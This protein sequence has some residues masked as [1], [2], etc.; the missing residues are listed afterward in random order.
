MINNQCNQ[1]PYNICGRIPAQITFKSDIVI[2]GMAPGND[3]LKQKKP[4]VGRSGKLL[5]ET[6][7]KAGFD[8]T[9]YITN[10]L[11]CK[12]LNEKNVSR[13]AIQLC[14]P[15]L[16][17]E[18]KKCSP[19]FILA[20]GNTA[21]SSV[22]NTFS[23]KV[24]SIH[25]TPIPYSEDS[26]ITVIPIFHPAKVLRNYGDYHTFLNGFLYAKQLYDGCQKKDPGVTQYVLVNESN[27][28][29][30]TKFLINHEPVMSCDIET[31]SLNPKKA[32]ILCIGFGI[33]KNLVYIYPMDFLP[34]IKSIFEDCRAKIVYHRSQFDT[35]VLQAKG[36]NANADHDT[37]LLHYCLDEN[38]G[39]HDLK[40]LASH[41]L[42]ADNY[43]EGIDK[44]NM[45]KLPK[46]KLYEYLAK[47]ADYTLQLFN[48]F[49]PEVIK[50]PNL[51]KLYHQ[52]LIPGINFLRRVSSNGFMINIPYLKKFKKELKSELKQMEEII[53]TDFAHLWNRDMYLSQTKAKSAPQKLNIRSPQQL[54]WIIYDLLKI[55]PTIYTEVKRSTNVEILENIEHSHKFIPH[56]LKYRKKH[57]LLTTY[58]EGIEDKI[59]KDERLRSTYNLQVTVTGRLSSESPNLQNIPRDSKVKNL[60]KAPKGYLLLEADYS[61]LEVRVLAYVSQDPFLIDLFEQD[62]DI[63]SEMAAK[64]FGPN[65]TDKQRTEVKSVNF[66]IVY[67]GTAFSISQEFGMSLREA[68]MIIDEW[69]RT[70]FKAKEYLDGCV[71]HLKSKQPFITPTGRCRRYGLVTMDTNQCNEAKNFAIQ[72]IASDLTLLSAIE[73]ESLIEPYNAKIINLVHDSIVIQVIN[74]KNKVE[75]VMELVYNIMHEIPIKWLDTDIN[76]KAEIKAGFSWGDMKKIE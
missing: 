60:F 2:V 58:I 19:K 5:R 68:Q 57:K 46:D 75:K 32:E 52:I 56:I 64:I 47:D 4:F 44:S 61:Q 42:G 31:T 18:I 25:G 74:D 8:Q 1:C 14:R 59:D 9:Y 51:N 72:S 67:G 62:K 10:A 48:L 29:Q 39:N 12:P 71:E 22:Q 28:E 37:I 76:F 21:I 20:L 36:I 27:A 54:A 6:L 13:E 73:L 33:T 41:F 55:K 16:I 3:E 65:F 38:V 11:L 17:E 23:L 69:F 34:Y 7:L 63:H 26:S 70:A 49:Y 15:R 30:V 53:A 43:A 40:T 35:A 50:D 66:R 45:D 24:T